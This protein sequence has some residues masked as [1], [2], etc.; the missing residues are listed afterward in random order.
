MPTKFRRVR[1]LINT[2]ICI[3]TALYSNS[4]WKNQDFF[5]ALVDMSLSIPAASVLQ[6]P[7]ISRA[8]MV[9]LH[10]GLLSK[11]VPRGGNVVDLP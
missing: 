11:S 10:P 4:F 6:T 8:A 3:C 1:H 9:H 5:E 7:G 2:R